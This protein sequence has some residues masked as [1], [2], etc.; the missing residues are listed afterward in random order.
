MGRRRLLALTGVGLAGATAGCLSGT[1]DDGAETPD[2]ATVTVGIRNRDD[3]E[4]EYEV[5]VRQGGRTTNSFS[6]VLPPESDRYEM[7]A[8]L[9]P[10]DEQHEVTVNTPA[11][12][13]GRTWDPLECGD[14]L[15]EATVENGDPAF[16]AEC[17]SG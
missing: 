9:R 8:T 12:Q 16:E 7:V 1:D 11:G 3:A 14:F 15:V 13:R 17:R 4:R 5:V 6:G 2:E 10:T